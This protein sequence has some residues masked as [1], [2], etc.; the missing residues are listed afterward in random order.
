MK[1]ISTISKAAAVAV[2][3][4]VVLFTGCGSS[5]TTTTSSSGSSVTVS[6]AYIIAGSVTSTDG[7][8]A[9]KSA[10]SGTNHGVWNF[11][12]A[13]GS[14][15]TISVAKGATK[16]ISADENGTVAIEMRTPA[17]YA[18]M[19]PNTTVIADTNETYAEQIT[20]LS[21]ADLKKDPVAVMKTS[22]E[23]YQ[24][25]Q[26]MV[27]LLTLV[28]AAQGEDSTLSIEDIDLNISV[29]TDGN[30]TINTLDTTTLTAGLSAAITTAATATETA[31][32][33]VV[34]K[35]IANA[36]KV[37]GILMIKSIES[38]A[39]VS[40]VMLES[41]IAD[42]LVDANETNEAAAIVAL[43]AA[44]TDINV[45]QTTTNADLNITAID[46]A[47]A[48]IE[49]ALPTELSIKDGKITFGETEVNIYKKADGT[50]TFT[51]TIDGTD[52]LTSFYDV[53]FSLNTGLLTRDFNSSAALGIS[54]EDI[55]NGENKAGDM[56]AL[57]I[58]GVDIN[59][60]F[61]T[62]GAIAV[63]INNG[64]L[65][66]ASTSIYGLPTTASY[67]FT[68]SIELDETDGTIAFDIDTLVNEINGDI[69]SYTDRLDQL[70]QQDGKYKVCLGV[71]YNLDGNFTNPY[72]SA[73]IDGTTYDA[74]VCGTIT[75]GTPTIVT[76]S[77]T[78][79]LVD[80]NDT[81]LSLDLAEQATI[82]LTLK[83]SD[84]NA[85]TTENDVVITAN[86]TALT[87][88]GADGS[89]SATYT[90]ASVGEVAIGAIVDRNGYD[91]ND[92]LTFSE[93]IIVFAEDFNATKSDV[94]VTTDS[95]VS[96]ADTLTATVR[97]N[98]NTLMPGE[99]V[100]FNTGSTSTVYG[101][102]NASTCT[103][104]VNGECSVEYVIKDT[105]FDANYV[106]ANL[107]FTITSNNEEIGSV[108]VDPTFGPALTAGKF[109]TSY[110]TVTE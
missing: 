2:L 45:T 46:T 31:A 75:V 70:A 109:I 99:V 73:S 10:T 20:G 61:D 100:T 51:K 17:G 83:G 105:A 28:E 60:T 57:S 53:A 12:T 40:S 6:D 67:N 95:V 71:D 98:A 22:P 103:T 65:G 43:D 58:G 52:E 3:G 101:D 27:Q 33:T 42:G 96:T 4:S 38:N 36:I 106:D 1:K 107:T 39:T 48:T 55:T 76:P 16:R 49:G 77:S 102:L 35:D 29:S 19:T 9:T 14:S 79:S 23:I 69:S 34:S 54:I 97:N 94:N 108:T 47:E 68:N 26:L 85:F 110:T 74:G 59:S 63:S 66:V 86:G 64:T 72:G 89:Y 90:A 25:N 41:A 24:L 87:T 78:L 92:T 8:V 44:N 88:T 56:V 81:S 15:A 21:L 91:A 18:M 62:D 93:T 104:D 13:P 80:V 84:T 5:D 32:N 30:I 11:A 50:Y 82:S 37:A 7:K